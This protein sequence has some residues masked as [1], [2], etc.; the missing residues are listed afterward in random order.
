MSRVIVKAKNP[1][2][3]VVVGLDR[4]LQHY[5]IQVYDLSAED[6][7]PFFWE[8][9]RSNYKLCEHMRE[10]CDL[11]DPATAK[12]FGNVQGDWD[13]AGQQPGDGI[14]YQRDGGETK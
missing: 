12:A 13:P 5:F 8:D 11:E 14:L 9:T 10:Y 1:N 6:E 4:P 3:E 2:H 7:E